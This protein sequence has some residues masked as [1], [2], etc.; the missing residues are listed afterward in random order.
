MVRNLTLQQLVRMASGP[1]S[2]G[3]LSRKSSAPW[4]RLRPVKQDP[5]ESMGFVS[6]GDNRY[7]SL[8]SSRAAPCFSHSID[9]LISKLKRASTIRLSLGICNFVRTIPR[10]LIPPS[11]PFLWSRVLQH[12]CTQSQILRYD[13]KLGH[14][15]LLHWIPNL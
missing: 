15:C 9:C 11:H 14:R 8:T 12:R 10:I 13:P 7:L 3:S 1:P 6:K 4:D 2:R 5:L